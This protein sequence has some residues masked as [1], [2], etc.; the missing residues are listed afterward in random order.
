MTATPR[1]VKR[2]SRRVG[3]EPSEGVPTERRRCASALTLA[4]REEIS[5]ALTGGRSMR[6]NAASLGRAPWTI[7][8]EI[9]RNGGQHGYRAP[10]ASLALLNLLKIAPRAEP[11]D[12][13]VG[14]G[15]VWIE[16]YPDFRQR[17]IDQGVG[18]R[19]CLVMEAIGARS[20][21]SFSNSAP[22]RPAV[23]ALVASLVALGVT[24]ATP[25][26]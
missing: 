22:L 26:E 16:A 24:E 1:R 2:R 6:S 23:D 13:L 7:S 12:V 8:R 5:R 25:L 4:E 9:G 21:T 18:R 11:L 10:F 20:A 15:S 14:A 17:W 3:L 19:W